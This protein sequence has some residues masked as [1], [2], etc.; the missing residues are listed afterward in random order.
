MLDKSHSLIK[1]SHARVIGTE[2]FPKQHFVLAFFEENFFNE[3]F[4]FLK[5]C[6]YDFHKIW[7]RPST[8][9][10]APVCAMTSK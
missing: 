9:K 10:A 3:N 7:Y 4:K 6:P 5:N 2:L 1:V 8:P